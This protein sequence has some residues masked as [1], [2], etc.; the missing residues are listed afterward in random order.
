MESLPSEVVLMRPFDSRH[1][2]NDLMLLG[3]TLKTP[4]LQQVFCSLL[5]ERK[6]I[7]VSN[8]LRYDPRLLL[9]K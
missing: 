9:I 2:E 6:V 4:I 3:D 5:L 8:M 7:L 1:E